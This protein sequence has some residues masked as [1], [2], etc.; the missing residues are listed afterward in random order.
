MF[1]DAFCLSNSN[2]YLPGNTI[3]FY[4]DRDGFG[5]ANLRSTLL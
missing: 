4:N 1:I 5:K 2:D 3:N